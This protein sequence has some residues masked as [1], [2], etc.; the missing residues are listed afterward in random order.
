MAP[1][2]RR[3]EYWVLG[4][5]A[6]IDVSTEKYPQKITLIDVS[7]LL[8]VIDGGPGWVASP[9][10]RTF[11]VMRAYRKG[12]LQITQRLHRIIFDD[13]KLRDHRNGDGLDNRRRNL[14]V[15]TVSQNNA[16]S[17]STAASGYRGVYRHAAQWRAAISVQGQLFYPGSF[18]DPI[19]AARAYDAA[20]RKHFG[21]FA[22]LNFPGEKE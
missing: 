16:N 20:A 9:S 1:P 19:L 18:D 7:D 3:N 21:E 13:G 17:H 10:R 6:A 4:S 2:R 14:R 8:L 12:K 22:R 15:A 11:Y 5:V